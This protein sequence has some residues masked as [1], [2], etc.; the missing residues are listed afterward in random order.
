MATL[1]IADITKSLV[2]KGFEQ[3][4]THHEMFWFIYNGKKTSIRTRVSHGEKEIGDS[5][6]GMMAKQVKLKRSEFEDLIACPLSKEQ[7][8]TILLSKGEVK[9]EVPPVAVPAAAP[10][11][12]STKKKKK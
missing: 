5:L 3:Q 9:V 11:Q 12:A 1:K 8:E 7:Y 10:S 2:V 6:I 4:I